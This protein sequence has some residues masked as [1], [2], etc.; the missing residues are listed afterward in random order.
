MSRAK[1]KGV[2]G[3]ILVAALV[4]GQSGAASAQSLSCPAPQTS[5]LELELMFGRNIG[6][7]PGVSEAQWREFL[8]REVTPRFPQGLTVFDA[9]GQWR[10]EKTKH[11]V[12]ERSKIVRIILPADAQADDKVEV[13]AAAYI[14]LFKQ[15]SVGIVRRPACV[16]FKPKAL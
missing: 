10:D 15:D 14:K 5:M 11:L 13:I 2:L 8:A 12:R 6:G 9:T 7:K 1:A 3:K 4:I 16:Y